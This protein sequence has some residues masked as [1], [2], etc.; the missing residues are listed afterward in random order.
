MDRE[1]VLAVLVALVCG[2][3]LTACGLW[4]AGVSDE[5]DGTVSERQAW[6]HLW[7]PFVPAALMLAALLGWAVREPADA[8][9]VPNALLWCSVPFAAIFVR[10]AWRA[11]RS[12]RAPGDDIAATVGL[13]RPRVVISHR[14]VETLDAAALAAALEHERAHVRHRD[15]L[16]LWLAQIGTDLLVPWP[17]AKRRLTCWRRALELARDDEARLY[18]ASGADLA[19]AIIASFRM[20]PTGAQSGVAARLSAD[21]TFLKQRVA[22][23]LKPLDRQPPHR[24][25]TAM[26]WLIAIA[27]AVCLAFLL[28]TLLGERAVRLL[29][30]LP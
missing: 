13:M 20:A 15:P 27:S 6:R 26:A 17:A 2:A 22:Q 14:L 10:A 28:G 25:R 11:V 4:P 9:R 3:T 12:M 24:E 1:L 29:F 30:G 5:S 7:L 21:Q 8:E 18:G 19:A 23:L 16:R